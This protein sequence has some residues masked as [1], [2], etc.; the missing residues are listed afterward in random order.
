MDDATDK[1]RVIIVDDDP[2]VRRALTR[3]FRFAEYD[4]TSCSSAPELL[5]LDL[6]QPSGPTC[7]VLDVHMPRVTGLDLL[8]ELNRRGVTI[9]AVFL[10]G[11]GDVPSSV[12]AMKAG[13]VE[14]FEKP[15]NEDELLEAVAAAVERHRRILVDEQTTR[16]VQERV[17]SLSPRER[18]VLEHVITGR[19]NKQVAARL[20]ISEK[21]VKVHRA[22]VM[23]KMAV[24]S[25]A[26]L[27]RAAAEVGITGPQ[28]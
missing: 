1:A 2:L 3:L 6:E 11:F 14:F 24:R 9:P 5:E 13:A 21:T 20:G 27:V 7:L 28:K 15:Y 18:E 26:E 25:V 16:L 17:D 19:L 10:T 22:R 23:E 8:D 4:V 12:R